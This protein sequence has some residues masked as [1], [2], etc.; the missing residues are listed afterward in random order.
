MY[1][2]CI[3]VL[4]TGDIDKALPTMYTVHPSYFAS[5]LHLDKSVSLSHCNLM[6]F[7]ALLISVELH[8]LGPVNGEYIEFFG[9]KLLPTTS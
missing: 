7:E 8:L 9:Y 1:A 5:F 4:L 2:S 6:D 3:Q